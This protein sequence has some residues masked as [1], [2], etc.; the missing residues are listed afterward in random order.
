MIDL[1]E[2]WTS[3]FGQ[4]NCSNLKRPTFPHNIA[5]F[6][7]ET[8]AAPVGEYVD[9]DLREIT[10]GHDAVLLQTVTW[11]DDFDDLPLAYE[12]GLAHGWHEV[13]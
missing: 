8:N 5:D 12:F 10:A 2:T 13:S 11:T 3:A 9:S 7:F 6:S 4:Q 1:E